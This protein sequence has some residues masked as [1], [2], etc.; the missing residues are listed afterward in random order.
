MVR[1]HHARYLADC[2]QPGIN[3]IIAADDAL[4][5]ET[6]NVIAYHPI[7]TTI[8]DNEIFKWY[9]DVE[10]GIYQVR[11]LGLPCLRH[12][13]GSQCDETYS[14]PHPWTV[15]SILESRRFCPTHARGLLFEAAL[16]GCAKA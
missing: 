6:L 7:Y 5:T 1:S 16:R 15:A 10:V 14:H 4:T 2:L 8:L 12:E 3:R 11:L 9:D 13:V